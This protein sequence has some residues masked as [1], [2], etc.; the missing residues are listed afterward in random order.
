M[1]LELAQW[2]SDSHIRAFGVFEYITLRAVLACGTALMIGLFAG[3]WVIRRLTAQDRPSGLPTP[4]IPSAENARRHGRRVDP[5]LHRCQHTTLGRLVQPLRVGCAAC[6]IRLGWIGW[7]DDYRKV[8]YRDPKAYN[9]AGS[10]LAAHE[11]RCCI[12]VSPLCRIRSRECRAVAA[13]PRLGA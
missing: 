11:R 8:F 5:E 1:L 13:V 10:F 3:P 6:H 4:P 9:L 2:L 7:P 12:G